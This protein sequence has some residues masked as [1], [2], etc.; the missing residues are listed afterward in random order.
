[1]P[2]ILL[3]SV[4][5]IRYDTENSELKNAH[6]LSYLPV[7]LHNLA[8]AVRH[9]ENQVPA[10][11]GGE[12]PQMMAFGVPNGQI[13]SC[14]LAWFAVSLTNYLRLVALI[15]LL[16]DRKWK[17]GDIR[18]KANHAEIRSHC[19]AYVKGVVPPAQ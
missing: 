11:F 16:E 15:K 17:P 6:A 14:F 2:V 19:T 8:E 4:E 5:G 12:A 7:G 13:L 3:D 9:Q 1:M 10:R 18:D